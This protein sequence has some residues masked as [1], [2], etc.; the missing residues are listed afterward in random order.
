MKTPNRRK[1]L[2]YIKYVRGLQKSL[3]TNRIFE[4]VGSNEFLFQQETHL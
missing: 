2:C 3:K 1:I 4:Y